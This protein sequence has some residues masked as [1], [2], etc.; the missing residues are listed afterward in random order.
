VFKAGHR[1]QLTISFADAVTPKLSPAPTV[2][3]YR[4]ATHPSSI[5]LPI[6]ED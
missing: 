4:D 6:V 5:T 1:I 3:I 2:S